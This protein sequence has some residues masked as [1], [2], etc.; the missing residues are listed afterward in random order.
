MAFPL[1]YLHSTLVY[2][3]YQGQ[4]HEHFDCEYLTVTDR[5]NFTFAIKYEVA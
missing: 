4:G 1:A 5:A 3:N 2:S